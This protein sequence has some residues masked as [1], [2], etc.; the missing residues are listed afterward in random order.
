MKTFY[1]HLQHFAENTEI[2]RSEMRDIV[3]TW[4]EPFKINKTETLNT[5]VYNFEVEKCYVI[6]T[7]VVHG[8]INR[9]SISRIHLIVNFDISFEEL[10]K[11]KE[12]G[13]FI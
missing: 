5:H 11:H 9:S 2:S 3:L 10:K 6:N 13:L 1:K 12:Y 7:N 8:V 4:Y